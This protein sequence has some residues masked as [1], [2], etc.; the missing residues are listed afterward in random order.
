M[1]E[2]KPTPAKDRES[3]R[4]L[5]T[6][7]RELVAERLPFTEKEDE[8]ISSSSSRRRRRRQVIKVVVLF[9]TMI[10]TQCLSIQN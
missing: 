7:A 6:A 5:I 4:Q 2:T 10:M 9:S 3:V 1:P 8:D